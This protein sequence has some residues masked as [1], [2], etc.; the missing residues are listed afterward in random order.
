MKKTKVLMMTLFVISGF[1]LAGC[2]GSNQSDASSPVELAPVTDPGVVAEA[3]LVYAD[4]IPL[5]FSISGQ[6]NEVLVQEGDRVEKHDVLARIGDTEAL[7]AQVLSAELMVLEAQQ[8]LDDL[9]ETADLVAAQAN[10]DLVQANQDLVAAERAWDEVDT[11]EFQQDLDDARIAMRDAKTD[12]EDAQDDL[13]EN[14]DLDED[15]PIR[16]DYEDAVVEAQQ[17]Y[18]EA[19]WDFEDLQ[20]QYDQAEAMLSVSQAA[21]V[22]AENQVAATENGPDSDDLALANANLDQ[23][24]AQLAAAELALKD[25]ELV[26]P[27]SG[28]VV[29]VE[30]TEGAMASPGQLA[31]VLVDDSAWYVETNDLTENEV[32]KIVEGQTVMITFDALPDRTF[33]GEV[34]AI[35][36]YFMERYGDITYVVKIRL[37]ES[38]ESLRWGMTAQVDFPEE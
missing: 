29:Q 30:L 23:A 28:R 37:L 1:V 8:Q 36:D 26:A 15:S 19:K 14:E 22:Y 7:E 17:A 2:A 32:V 27:I 33:M 4:S 5:S 21:V 34:D 9:N 24:N 11:D 18:D 25:A 10:A 31:V 20:Y 6:V 3:N 12:L 13:A 38:D 16:E 35:S